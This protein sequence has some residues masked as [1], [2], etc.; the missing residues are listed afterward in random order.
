MPTRYSMPSRSLLP[1]RRPFLV[2][3][4]S[5]T[6]SNAWPAVA[7]RF[8]PGLPEARFLL[9]KYIEK[10]TKPNGDSKAAIPKANHDPN[11]VRPGKADYPAALKPRL[12]DRQLP[13]RRHWEIWI[14]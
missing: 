1:I 12:G 9:P 13:A 5:A 4:A 2:F 6:V 11:A 7:E 10:L 14:T 8:Q 3:I